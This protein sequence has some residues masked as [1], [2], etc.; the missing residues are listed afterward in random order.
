[1]ID[2]RYSLL[3][4]DTAELLKGSINYKEVRNSLNS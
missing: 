3:L 1:M 4:G 2:A